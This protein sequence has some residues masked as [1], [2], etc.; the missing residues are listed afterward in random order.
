MSCDVTT[1]EGTSN[2]ALQPQSATACKPL[3][4]KQEYASHDLFNKNIVESNR[5]IEYNP[6]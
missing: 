4:I 3:T 2:Q 1:W 6:R 5:R